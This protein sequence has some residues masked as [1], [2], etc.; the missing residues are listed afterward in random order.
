DAVRVG[1]DGLAKAAGAGSAA[2]TGGT[3][4]VTYGDVPLLTGELLRDFVAEHH[5]AQH[6]ATIMTARIAD[7]T[8]YGRVLR[9]AD[10]SVQAVVEHKD[11][12]VEQ[13]GIDEVNSGI[14]AFD[15]SWIAQALEKVTTDNAQGELYLTDVVAI[16]RADGLGVG[17]YTVDDVWQTEGVNDRVQLA[18]L[19]AELNRRT[20]RRWMHA[21]VTVVDPGSTWV[22]VTVTLDPDVVLHPGTQLHGSTSVAEGAAIGPDTT[23]RDVLVGADAAVVRTHGSESV[24][25]SGAQVGPFAYLRPGSRLRAG[26]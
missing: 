16:A 5:N 18:G 3:V 12:T 20:L 6:P 21:G 9:Q 8:G 15:A 26:G 7:P 11:A 19:G 22:D 23:L 17:A 13:R 4:V 1:L 2:E 10:G 24:I 25:E 14:Y